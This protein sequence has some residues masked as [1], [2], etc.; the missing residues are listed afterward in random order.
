MSISV[1]CGVG[2]SLNKKGNGVSERPVSVCADNLDLNIGHREFKRH[3]P[4]EMNTIRSPG[5]SLQT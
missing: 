3:T 4:R 2:E 1:G 5:K